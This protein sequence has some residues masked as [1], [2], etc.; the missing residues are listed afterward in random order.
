[1][2]E[3]STFSVEKVLSPGVSYLLVDLAT[4]KTSTTL[5]YRFTPELSARLRTPPSGSGRRD[6]LPERRVVAVS[7]CR[8]EPFPPTNPN[9]DNPALP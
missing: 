7:A 5:A 9:G 2:E 8:R 1:V 3:K 4:S 6:L